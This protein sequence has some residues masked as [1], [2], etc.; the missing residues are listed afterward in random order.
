[1]I[2][3]VKKKLLNISINITKFYNFLM[4]KKLA[5]FIY[6]NYKKQLRKITRNSERR[7]LKL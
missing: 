6:K 1:M 5:Y 7:K 4:L 3:D 2:V